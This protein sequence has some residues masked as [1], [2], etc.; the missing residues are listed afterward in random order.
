MVL[1]GRV[2]SEREGRRHD[3]CEKIPKLDAPPSSMKMS[4]KFDIRISVTEAMCVRRLRP[5]WTDSLAFGF[6][7]SAF[8]IL[9]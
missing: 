1:K 6:Q 9:L 2:V 5:R 3:K 4:Q 8:T 7:L